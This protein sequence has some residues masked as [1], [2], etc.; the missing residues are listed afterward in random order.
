MG[1]YLRNIEDCSIEQ[2]EQF[3]NTFDD[4][5][6]I[7]GFG[8]IRYY[9]V[10]ELFEERPWDSPS[11]VNKVPYKQFFLCHTDTTELIGCIA[12]RPYMSAP[13]ID[14]FGFNIGYSISPKWR[15]HGY[16]KIQLELMLEAA[17]AGGF[18][19]LYIGASRLNIPSTKTILACGGEEMF[20]V[21]EDV[22]Y[23]FN[24]V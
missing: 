6:N 17:K 3:C 23:R 21:K 22:A 12:F 16:A 7:P 19:S 4:R 20:C 9:T 5:G 13:L 8:G 18:S 2:V 24:L 1:F 15:G 10:E 14:G 11:D